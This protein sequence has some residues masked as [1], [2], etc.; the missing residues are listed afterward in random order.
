MQV[1]AE[2]TEEKAKMRPFEKEENSFTKKIYKVAIHSV[3]K[4]KSTC[5]TMS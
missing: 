5:V 2:K 3:L 4:K 1:K